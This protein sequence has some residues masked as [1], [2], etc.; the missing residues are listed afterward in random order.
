MPP[1]QA[2]GLDAIDVRILSALQRDGRM[3]IQ[4]LAGLAGLSPRPCL[5]RVRRLRAEGIIA[6]F[7]AAIDIEKLAKPVTIFTELT[8]SR[9]ARLDRVEARLK[10]IEETVECWEISGSSDYLVR[11]VCE[12]LERYEAL[13]NQLLGDRRLGIARMQSHI[14][15]R[16]VAH[17]TGYPTTLF[18]PRRR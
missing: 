10:A 16:P 5:E 9:Q 6:G 8:L 13:T 17:F 1:K 7:H 15:L 3:T 11:F 14:A 2:R 12:D 18:G 4:K